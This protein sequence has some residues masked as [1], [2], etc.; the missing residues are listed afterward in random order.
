MQKIK[1]P[2]AVGRWNP[3]PYINSIDR[4]VKK[5]TDHGW[6]IVEQQFATTDD[7]RKF[8]GL[9]NME[10][11]EFKNPEYGTMIGLRNSWT[12]QFADR[13]VIGN[14]VFVCANMMFCGEMQIGRRNTTNAAKDMDDRLALLIDNMAGSYINQGQRVAAYK[15]RELSRMEMHDAV[16]EAMK[17]GILPSSKIDS[18]LNE[19]NTPRHAEHK[20]ETLWTLL[21][22]FTEVGK[23]WPVSTLA[24]R[25][26]E[27]Q[28]QLDT[29]CRHEPYQ[30]KEA[31][32]EV[33]E[34]AE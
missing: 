14:D 5:C 11:P 32:A 18:V 10:H 24:G 9:I 28:K 27:L 2:E 1:T 3:Q 34:V 23:A 15:E 13:V 30:M 29:I 25:T 20:G 19:Y 4:V 7:D 16:C 12:K 21:N 26:I 8:F 17:E 33:L 22:A 6:Q 31:A